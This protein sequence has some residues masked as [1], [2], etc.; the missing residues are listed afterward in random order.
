MYFDAVLTET[1]SVLFNGTPDATRQ[2][3]IEN[4][5]YLDSSVIV[6]KGSTL[7]YFTVDQYLSQ[8]D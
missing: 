6:C 8:K 4:R 1:E 3:L 2:W 5:D 7:R